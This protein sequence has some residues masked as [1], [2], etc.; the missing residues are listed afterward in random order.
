MLLIHGF[1]PFLGKQKTLRRLTTQSQ[2]RKVAPS[3]GTTLIDA[4]CPLPHMTERRTSAQVRDNVRKFG[5][6]NLSLLGETPPYSYIVHR[7]GSQASSAFCVLRRTSLAASHHPA[8]L[9]LGKL[10]YYSCSTPL[11]VLALI[12]EHALI[13]VSAC[14]IGWRRRDLNP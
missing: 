10:T 12:R 3:V 2:G 7:C 4:A 9:W 5:A 1:A 14:L 11:A 8:T 6:V 13:G